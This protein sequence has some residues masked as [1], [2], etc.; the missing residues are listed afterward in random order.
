MKKTLIPLVALS[1]LAIAFYWW[2]R[3]AGNEQENDD[4]TATKSSLTPDVGKGSNDGIESENEL[5]D[6][7]KE[8]VVIPEGGSLDDLTEEELARLEAQQAEIRRIVS[9]K[10]FKSFSQRLDAIADAVGMTSAQKEALLNEFADQQGNGHEDMA[11]LNQM[12]GKLNGAF[13]EEALGN[14]LDENQMEAYE[15]YLATARERELEQEARRETKHLQALFEMDGERA[16]QVVQALTQQAMQ[17]NEGVAGEP[18]DVQAVL[19][20]AIAAQ[21]GEDG[22]AV[23]PVAA[24][25]Q[26]S[27][28]RQV[29]AKLDALTGILNEEELE[30]YRTYLQQQ[31]S[32]Q[33][34]NSL[35]KRRQ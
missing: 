13:L 30:T 14:V 8:Q 7:F 3:N 25:N 1:I 27:R 15:D 4:Q 23:N 2:G 24:L 5:S 26:M 11:A 10:Q 16:E 17:V 29:E 22:G 28:D 18:L 20:E 21:Q 31:L 6:I 19:Q 33:P 34:Q 32:R 12:L 35:R 9:E